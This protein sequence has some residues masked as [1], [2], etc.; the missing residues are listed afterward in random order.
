LSGSLRRR[1]AVHS[2]NHNTWT[3]IFNSGQK[4]D[5]SPLADQAK[6]L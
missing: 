1:P 4:K 2:I 5:W 3:G 6:G